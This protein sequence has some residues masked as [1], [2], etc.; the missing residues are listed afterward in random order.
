MEQYTINSGAHR[1]ETQRGEMDERSVLV[2]PRGKNRRSGCVA[3]GE[4][5]GVIG[6]DRSYIRYITPLYCYCLYYIFM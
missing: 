3:S 5:R 4:E 6:S 2:C 1:G